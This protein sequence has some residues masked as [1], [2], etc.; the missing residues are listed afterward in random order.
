MKVIY[1]R[2]FAKIH[3]F[4]ERLIKKIEIYRKLFYV[5]II[6]SSVLFDILSIYI[7]YYFEFIHNIFYIFLRMRYKS[8]NEKRNLQIKK[9]K[10][11]YY[12]NQVS[13]MMEKIIHSAKEKERNWISLSGQNVNKRTSRIYFLTSIAIYTRII[14]ESAAII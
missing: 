1:L 11:K 6:R 9:K 14:T 4:R 10:N 13:D 8:A 7:W 2:I 12:K 3:V 5:N